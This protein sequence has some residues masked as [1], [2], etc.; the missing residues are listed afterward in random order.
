MYGPWCFVTLFLSLPLFLTNVGRSSH[1]YFSR[2]FLIC[3]SSIQ[4]S[5]PS[6]LVPIDMADT[7]SSSSSQSKVLAPSCYCSSTYSP[8]AK[9]REYFWSCCPF[10][11]LIMASSNRTLSD[12]TTSPLT[13]HPDADTDTPEDPSQLP[14]GLPTF[15]NFWQHYQIR[16]SS[17]MTGP[18]SSSGN[19]ILALW[20]P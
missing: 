10:C 6:S 19:T 2:S 4:P 16:F 12:V 18:L 9:C 3:F 17:L 11:N 20:P 15:T 5:M 14:R 7:V 8:I 1:L 13:S